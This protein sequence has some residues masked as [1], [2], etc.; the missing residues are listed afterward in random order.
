MFR[1]IHNSSFNK[2]LTTYISDG[3]RN[4][5]NYNGTLPLLLLSTDTGKM[6]G[7]ATQM[8]TS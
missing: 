3:E 8:L 5:L 1:W 7:V 6:I 2:R 4:V